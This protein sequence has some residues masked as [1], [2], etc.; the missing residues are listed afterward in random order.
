MLA[1]LR[2][3]D[4]RL[5]VATE[6]FDFNAYVRA[7]AD[8][9]NEDLS[10]FFFDIRKDCLYC[11]AAADPKRRAYRTVLD[12]LFHALVR[13]AAPIIP[14][15]AE[16]VWQSRYPNADESV[17]FLEW[18]DFASLLRHSR[19][20]GNPSPIRSPATAPEMDP[21]LRGD[22]GSW[23]L[24]AELSDK[25]HRIRR[26]RDAVTRRVEPLRREKIIGSSLETEV[27]LVCADFPDFDAVRSI[28][29]AE[30]CIVAEVKVTQEAIDDSVQDDFD[31]M[32]YSR[33]VKT[34]RHKCGRCWRL[35][36]EVADD[37]A[38]CARCETVLSEE[39]AA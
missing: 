3:L 7:L 30:I 8:F 18:P 38:L 20:G 26:A 1:L 2:D 25:W 4:N 11:D 23:L 29:F 10:A 6:N 5:R 15:T 14:F 13:Y 17:H 33:A 35:L 39:V 34:A 21:R 22:D 28:D 37:G 9:A 27:S 12:T 36:P 19:E 16:E 31:R 32:F 24:D